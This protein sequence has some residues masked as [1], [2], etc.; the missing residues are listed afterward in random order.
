MSLP[1]NQMS[2]EQEICRRIAINTAL[3]VKGDGGIGV[4]VSLV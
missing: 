3:N 1:G 4:T 2:C